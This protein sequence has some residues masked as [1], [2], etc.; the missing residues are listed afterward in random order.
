MAFEAGSDSLIP[1]LAGEFHRSDWK[2]FGKR[3]VSLYQKPAQLTQVLAAS[4][5][6]RTR[7]LARLTLQRLASQ[8]ATAALRLY[9]RAQ[10]RY[11]LSAADLKPVKMALA[12]RLML[13]REKDHRGW[14][15]K[16]LAE[17]GDMAL[18]ELRTRLAIWESD[19]PA[20]K[21]W[22][23]RMPKTGRDDVQWTYWL[24]RAEEQTG[25]V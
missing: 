16:T 10:Q 3:M 20:I 18:L 19:W 15:D 9:P 17:H 11:H 12:R 22:I 25:L 5:D 24:A 14:L 7:A 8:D 2:A 1:Y 23:V 6:R 21:R 13:D 4:K